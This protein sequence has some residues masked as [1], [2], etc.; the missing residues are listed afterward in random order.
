MRIRRKPWARPELE[1]SPFYVPDACA[2]R[3]AWALRFAVERPICLE[4]GCGK[5]RFAGPF[6]ANNP[7]INLIAV[8]IKSEMLVLAKRCIEQSVLSAGREAVDNA[9]VTSFDIARIS[10]VFGEGDAVD[11][12][13]INFPNPW[14]KPAHKKRRLTHT[15]QLVQYKAFLAE[16][17]EIHFKTDDPG[18][19]G[20]SHRYFDEAGFDIVK[21]DP[22]IYI[23]GVPEGTV[24][25]EHE[26]RFTAEGKPIM[27]MVAVPRLRD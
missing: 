11:R 7:D 1:A 17:G 18:L 5:G 12:I 26:E 8:D 23:N 22:D 6:A 27:Y 16:N 10:E 2:C 19:Y 14:P 20:D 3:G 13:F 9:L 15:R 25:T 4:L 21:D 24:L